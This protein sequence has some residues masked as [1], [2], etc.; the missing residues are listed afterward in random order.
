MM[1]SPMARLPYLLLAVLLLGLALSAPA[2]AKP[3]EV[4]VGKVGLS[5]MRND[6]SASV[7]VPVRYPIEMVGH[8][9]ELS[10]RLF[11]PGRKGAARTWSWGFRERVHGGRLRRPDRRRHFTYVHRL[12]LSRALMGEVRKDL[13][14]EVVAEAVRDADRDG[15]AE[16]RSRDRAAQRL[17]VAAGGGGLCSS[18]PPVRTRPGKRVAVGLPVCA[19]GRDW[20]PLELPRHGRAAIR[21][22]KLVYHPPKRFRGR[23]TI[24]LVGLL[25]FKGASGSRFTPLV[26]VDVPVTVTAAD[27]VVVRALGDSVTAGFG[28]YSDGSSMGIGELY[29]CR[30]AAREFDDACSS[31]S[32]DRNSKGK[33][34]EYAPDFG[35]A[36]NV[37]WAAQWAN[38]HGIT[39]Y[40]NFAV[41]GSE[42][43][44]WA[45]GGELHSTTEQIE[46]E[47]PDYVLMTMGANP[48]LSEMLFGVD[49]MGCAIYAD[50]FG[51]YRECVEEAFAEVH[52][53]ANLRALYADLVANTDATI[54]LMRYHLSVPSTALAY[55]A[56]QIAAMGKL[57]NREIAAVAAEVNPKR[58]QVVAPPHF[59]V[60]IDISPVFPSRYSCSRL[61]YEVDGPSVQSTPTQDELEVLHPLSFCEGPP[62]GPPWVIGGD[63]GIHPSA[64]GYQQMASQVPPPS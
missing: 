9:A 30:P 39:D 7:L 59:D 40:K 20:G 64:A 63:T 12:N 19:S 61:G 15:R 3:A 6:G 25:N 17:P 46:S 4:R 23:Q 51:G 31:N 22:G 41:S 48:L 49:N 26:F 37:S 57:L 14:V 2:A 43:S 1:S 55:S 34:V 32:L 45:P 53:Q 13:R 47:D 58:L 35:L 50:V 5:V 10:L 11:D 42:P 21:G 33:K 56:A 60:G 62:K 27:G 54:Y 44:D 29:G 28:Y 52:L 16:L 38:F 24:G 18:V 8:A 36:N